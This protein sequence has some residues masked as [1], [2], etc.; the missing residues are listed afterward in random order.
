[1]THSNIQT[2][3]ADNFT[4][5]TFALNSHVSKL[6]AALSAAIVAAV[7]SPVPESLK[8]LTW[9]VILLV[10]A[11]TFAGVYA[12]IWTKT[13]ESHRLVEKLA[14]KGVLYAILLLIGFV[15]CVIFENWLTAH[16]MGLLMVTREML[17]LIEN[18]KR[19]MVNGK[20]FGRLSAFLDRIG[21]VLSVASEQAVAVVKVET[22]FSQEQPVA[23]VVITPP[24]KKEE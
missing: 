7:G 8:K 17:S 19:L 22:P 20:D 6:V 2:K 23:T 18:A 12:A 14:H 3:F 24:E 11:D 16:A 9:L 1:M 5:R 13:L 15:P 21:S 4:G 10:I